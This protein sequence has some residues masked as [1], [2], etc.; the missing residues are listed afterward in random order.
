MNVT[1]ASF[2]KTKSSLENLQSIE[3]GAEMEEGEEVV[4]ETDFIRFSFN[5][6]LQYPRI[7]L[8]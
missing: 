8:Q 4:I 2:R 1:H 6:R 3:D 7:C 5:G